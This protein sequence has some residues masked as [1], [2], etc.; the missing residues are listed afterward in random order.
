MYVNRVITANAERASGCGG[1]TVRW[2][3]QA[4]PTS[5]V[6]DAGKRIDNGAWERENNPLT[7][8]SCKRGKQVFG[9][10]PRASEQAMLS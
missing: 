10:A 2:E 3:V 1:H 4:R 8:R 7:R 5:L 9:H 6:R